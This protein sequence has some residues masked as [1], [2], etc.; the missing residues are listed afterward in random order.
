MPGVLQEAISWLVQLA[1]GFANKNRPHAL[2]SLD[3]PTAIRNAFR[4]YSDSQRQFMK[5]ADVCSQRGWPDRGAALYC[6]WKC[7]QL[8]IRREELRFEHL[9]AL[10]EF[11]SGAWNTLSSI[12]DRLNKRW[13]DVDEGGVL[14]GNPSYKDVTTKIADMEKSRASMDG[15]LLDGPLRELQQ[16]SEYR[17]ARQAIYE[18]VHELNRRLRDLGE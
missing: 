8:Y 6:T 17:A 1:R 16:H 7:Q 2:N 13:S 12:T 18:K 14:S 10:G 15:D 11:E 3:H 5:V 9:F 4:E